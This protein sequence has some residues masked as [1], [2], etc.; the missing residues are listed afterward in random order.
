MFKKLYEE[1]E[2]CDVFLEVG[3]KEYGAHRLI[4][5]ASSDVFKVSKKKE[6]FSCNSLLATRWIW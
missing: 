2:M 5:C 3:S 4:L 6:Y 1:Q